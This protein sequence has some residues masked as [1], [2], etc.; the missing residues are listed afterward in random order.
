VSER[1]KAGQK[2]S[3]DNGVIYGT[4]NIM[5]YD[6]KGSAY[7]INPD[8]AETVRMIFEMYLNR[9]IGSKKIANEL[10]RLRR[11]A[12]SGEVKW[13]CANVGRI[14]ANPTYMG[15]LVYG[16]SFSNNYLEQKR[17][18][19]GDRSTLMMVKGDF[20]PIISEEDW[21]KAEAIRKSRLVEEAFLPVLGL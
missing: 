8:Q 10:T 20:D 9:N 1:V 14:I 21:R 7:V 17:I 16:K 6:R 2:I 19:N 18:I 5:G 3:R 15:Y 4:G 13:T 12:A 11:K